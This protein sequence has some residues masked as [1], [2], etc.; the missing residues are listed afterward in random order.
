MSAWIAAHRKGLLG[1][2]SALGGVL[3]VVAAHQEW[4]Q[5]AQYA[6]IGVA[7]L[8]AAGVYRVPNTPAPM[9]ANLTV[10]RPA[11]GTAPPVKPG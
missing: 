6:A 2:L 8:S 4:G 11:G 5:W 9:P 1:A 10:T 3:A 7:V